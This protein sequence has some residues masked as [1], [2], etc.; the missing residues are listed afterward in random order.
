MLYGKSEQDLM[1]SPAM[2]VA[3][4]VSILS[5]NMFSQQL[6]FVPNPNQYIS[7]A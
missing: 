2:L 4:R 3:I 6:V 1:T 5:Q 7:T